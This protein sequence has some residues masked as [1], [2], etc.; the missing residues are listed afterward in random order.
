[1]DFILTGKQMREADEFTISECKIDSF[2][3]MKNAGVALAETAGKIAPKGAILIVCGGGNNGG[4]GLVCARLLKEK[5]RAVQ[6]V[7]LR[8]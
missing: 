1:M 3:L 2:S 4:D 5:N 7:L 8:L 6:V